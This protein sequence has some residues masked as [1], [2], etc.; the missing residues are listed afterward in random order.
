MSQHGSSGFESHMR[1]VTKITILGV[2]LAVIALAFYWL[3]I[4]AGT[5]LPK[6]PDIATSLN[7]KV[8]HFA[9]FFGLA[10]LLC[11]VT[12]SRQLVK[13][14]VAIGIVAMVY[15]AL[16]EMTQSFIPGRTPDVMDFVA[17]SVG[18]WSAIAC[19]VVARKV[20][21]ALTWPEPA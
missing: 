9:A 14:F 8:K 18:V 3:L 20:F 2:R 21:P 5:H 13:R 12:T 1:P 19:Y 16:D 15:A 11:Y 4:F 6:V 17:D 10:T 7:D